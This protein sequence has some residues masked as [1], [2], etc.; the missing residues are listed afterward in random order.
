MLKYNT[1][2]YLDSCSL[3]E[4]DN[5]F[6]QEEHT[7]FTKRYENCYDITTDQRYN[8]WVEIYHPTEVQSDSGNCLQLAMHIKAMYLGLH[9]ICGHL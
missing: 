1:S 5:P 4:I 8:K 2:R 7:K 3:S 6:S 9:Q